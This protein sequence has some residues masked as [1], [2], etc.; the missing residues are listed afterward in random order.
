[1]PHLGQATGQATACSYGVGVSHRY[2]QPAADRLC[3]GAVPIHIGTDLVLKLGNDGSVFRDFRTLPGPGQ[4]GQAGQRGLRVVQILAKAAEDRITQ[5][6]P[7]NLLRPA[8]KH[9]ENPAKP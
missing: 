1:M 6:K 2:A 5:G 4:G 3:L 9:R 8:R 7:K